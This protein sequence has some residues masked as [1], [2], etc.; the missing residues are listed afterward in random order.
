MGYPDTGYKVMTLF[1]GNSP[2]AAG[3]QLPL[4]TKPGDGLIVGI[5]QSGMAVIDALLQGGAGGVLDIYIQSALD[6]DQ[7]GGGTWYDVAH[8][9]QL[10]AAAAQVRWLLTVS[11][12]YNRISAVP[13]AANP[14]SGTPTLAANTTIP[15]CL[16]NALRVVMIAG[17]GTTL[18]A[19]QTIKVALS[20]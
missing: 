10:A 3:T 12:G 11:R 8:Y 18:G 14:L 15:D 6:A 1:S 4:T 13:S 7:A 5:A 9:T 17:A 16:G 2:G 20:K 19:A